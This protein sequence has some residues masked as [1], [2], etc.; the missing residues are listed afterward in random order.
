VGDP[1]NQNGPSP[2]TTAA[3]PPTTTAPPTT[4]T[5]APTTTT[6]APSTTTT[7]PFTTTTA[8]STTTTQPP[9]TTT[10]PPSTTTAA[11]DVTTTAPAATTTGAVAGPQFD[12]SAT[13]L[14]KRGDSG[15]GSALTLP[16]G[17]AAEACWSL[18]N[19]DLVQLHR[20]GQPV[21]D[22]DH[23][24]D[25]SCP[26]PLDGLEPGTHDFKLVP[27]VTRAGMD[28]AWSP[29]ASVALTLTL[30]PALAVTKFFAA[31]VP[32]DGATQSP[33]DLQIP[34]GT[35]VKLSWE[36]TF[37]KQ[38][39]VTVQPDGGDATPMDAIDVT[40]DDGGRASGD[41]VVDPGDKPTTYTLIALD[42]DQRSGPSSP[43]GVHFHDAGELVSAIARVGPD[44]SATLQIFAGSLAPAGAQGDAQSAQTGAGDAV[45]L[46]WTATAAASARLTAELEGLK[47]PP[48]AASR[49]T[50]PDAIDFAALLAGGL[51][52]DLDEA[53][54]GQG[55][56]L[57]DPGPG[58]P[59]TITLRVQPREAQ[60]GEQAA[61]VTAQVANFNVHLLM[62]DR[63]TSALAG[64]MCKLELPGGEVLEG[65]TDANGWLRLT[66]PK[67]QAFTATVHMFDGDTETASWEL[68][69]EADPVLLAGDTT[70][71][72]TA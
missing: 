49:A 47:P 14:R 63:G 20:D 4:T 21:G 39:V 72:L 35:K 56:L 37:A 57:L 2:T 46:H 19:A 15:S 29:D 33:L 51:D 7:A 69:I 45:T 11:P 53:G 60:S 27:G 50:T 38:V 25:G 16:V 30:V 9:G 10:P 41:L 36:V 40:A 3:P 61:Q 6:T 5:L 70:E 71:E 62:D 31:P 28:P 18:Q 26:V 55:D 44:A 48:D 17:S 59:A 32:D 13:G 24:T 34:I 52:L 1:S 8:Q 68:N 23:A 43:L 12:P 42:G 65:S 64:M 54:N 67:N 22:P 66:L 58:Q